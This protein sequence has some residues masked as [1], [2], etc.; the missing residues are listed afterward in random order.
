MILL[1]TVG[2]SKKS[3]FSDQIAKF[4][5]LENLNKS[6]VS[7][8]SSNNY[9]QKSGKLLNTNCCFIKNNSNKNCENLSDEFGSN[10]N[11]GRE[12]NEYDRCLSDNHKN[13]KNNLFFKEKSNFS[14]NFDEK[15][16]SEKSDNSILF[17]KEINEENF[18]C[19]NYESSN[20]EFSSINLNENKND[21]EN[22]VVVDDDDV[23]GDN[24]HHDENKI[25]LKNKEKFLPSSKKK[26]SSVIIKNL[27]PKLTRQ[28]IN[29]SSEEVKNVLHDI[30]SFAFIDSSG[31]DIST[32]SDDDNK[33]NQL[34]SFKLKKKSLEN[35]CGKIEN[36][37][38][39]LSENTISLS[40]VTSDIINDQI[41]NYNC[42]ENLTDEKQKNS[43]NCFGKNQSY[44]RIYTEKT[45]SSFYFI[46]YFI[47]KKKTT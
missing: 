36:D 42:V 18:L 34:S 1:S 4:E 20:D 37:Y 11:I 14:K 40:P 2:E 30:E 27:T 47:K 8:K 38:F 15:T 17:E 7:I 6:S 19:E 35:I 22:I 12:N 13:Q 10:N 24:H 41:K 21:V 43:F 5:N 26:S 32:I 29:K 16:F 28:H 31:G 45:V 46:C 3:N 23:D 39:I 44:A 9:N 33:I 25:K